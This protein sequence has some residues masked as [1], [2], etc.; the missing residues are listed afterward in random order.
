MSVQHSVKNTTG[1]ITKGETS[2][3]P[4]GRKSAVRRMFFSG[5]FLPEA[6]R[7]GFLC[8]EVF[9]ARRRSLAPGTASEYSLSSPGG[10]LL[11]PFL[12]DIAAESFRRFS[13]D[14]V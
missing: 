1:Y 10:A 4:C 13:R 7:E 14:F 9:S 11:L 8:P 2:M 5:K 3:L 6:D 12:K